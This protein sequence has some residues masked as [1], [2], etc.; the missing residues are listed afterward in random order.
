MFVVI[1]QESEVAVLAW[2]CPGVPVSGS[3][4]ICESNHVCVCVWLC[5]GLGVCAACLT[6]KTKA[7]IDRQVAWKTDLPQESSKGRLARNVTAGQGAG[8]GE[9][10]VE[11]RISGLSDPRPVQILRGAEAQVAETAPQAKRRP[12]AFQEAK[13]RILLVSWGVDG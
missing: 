3:S 13:G 2:V 6:A 10:E 8:P 11:S 4:G 12:S 1:T 5:E 9:R 7:S